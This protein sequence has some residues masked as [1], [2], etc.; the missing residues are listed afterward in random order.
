MWKL[1]KSQRCLES[2]QP[3]KEL[4]KPDAPSVVPSG[5]GL[6]TK[7]TV[8]LNPPGYPEYFGVAMIIRSLVDEVMFFFSRSVEQ[9][10]WDCISYE[11]TVGF[12]GEQDFI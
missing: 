3:N 1:V 5:P 9:N 2:D 12:L 7:R 8:P 4:K 6:S 11:T 10:L